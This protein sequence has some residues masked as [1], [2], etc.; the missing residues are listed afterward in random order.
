MNRLT[1][2]CIRDKFH[3]VRGLSDRLIT[4]LSAEDACVQSMPDASPAKWHLA[5]VTWFFETF[6]LESLEPNFQ[7]FHPSYRKMFNSYYNAV[8]AQH[9]RP[10]RGM[11]TRPTLPEV[12]EY[13]HNVDDRI[14]KIIDRANQNVLATIELGCHHEQQHQELLLMDIKHLLSLN[15]LYPPY[16]GCQTRI[17]QP[18]VERRWV[19]CPGGLLTVGH[20]D[21][22]FRFD[23]ETP[24]HKVWIEP[25]SLDSRPISNGEYL[26][27]VSD[28]GYQT[29]TM[30]LAD[31]WATIQEK[32]WRSPLYWR[33][34]EGEWFEFTL[35]GL[36][37]LDLNAPVCHLSHYEADAF[38]NWAGARLPTEF[39]WETIATDEPVVGN[40]LGSGHLH[41]RRH[42]SANGRELLQ[43]YGDVWEWTRS[44][45]LP[46][47]GF[48]AASGAI[49]EY[50]G[51][52][53]SNQVVLKGGSCT[54]P[55][56]HV[57]ATYRNFFY[58]HHRWQFSGIRLAREPSALT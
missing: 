41:P 44:A 43:I 15:P 11:L 30:W 25:F 57:R 23:N 5:H 32:R 48:T 12:I 17:A 20:D 51:K 29:P 50:N 35:G 47:R 38:C 34:I 28:G 7:P 55:K 56:G 31:G 54:T 6:V 4:P 8:G 27:F 9:P 19:A 45:Y 58:P 1:P 24:P 40:F 16:L 10:E 21:T 52:F 22:S 18:A 33:E 42:G 46:Y 36:E 13:R 49:G 26:D 3:S 39:E 14:Q 53:M 37:S 2:E